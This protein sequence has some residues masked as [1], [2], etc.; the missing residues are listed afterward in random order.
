MVATTTEIINMVIHVKRKERN[1]Y[2]LKAFD[3][4]PSDSTRKADKMSI[5][6]CYYINALPVELCTQ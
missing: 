4:L 6:V 2:Q 5:E 1:F 3:S